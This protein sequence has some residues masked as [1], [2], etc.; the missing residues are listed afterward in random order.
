MA[1]QSGVAV[2]THRLLPAVR[3]RQLT[4]VAGRASFQA[5][6]WSIVRL[7]LGTARLFGGMGVLSAAAEWHLPLLCLRPLRPALDDPF[8]STS[9]AEFWYLFITHHL[10]ATHVA[11]GYRTIP[12]A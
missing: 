9:V 7:A 8:A 1:S 6:W 5:L 3:S 12:L 4:A 11:V 2:A 10:F